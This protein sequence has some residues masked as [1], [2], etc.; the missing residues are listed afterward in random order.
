MITIK[1]KPEILEE[2][3]RQKS[4]VQNLM[5]SKT[6]YDVRTNTKFNEAYS[7]KSQGRVNRF[8]KGSM[9][10]KSFFNAVDFPNIDKKEKPKPMKKISEKQFCETQLKKPG[11]LNPSKKLKTTTKK[12]PTNF[13]LFFKRFFPS[14]ILSESKHSEIYVNKKFAMRYYNLFLKSKLTF[15]EFDKEMTMG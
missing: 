2:I 6:M 3:Q 5:N 1:E 7:R 15:E 11:L 10:M 12:P 9:S 14:C 13:E 4:L 8:V